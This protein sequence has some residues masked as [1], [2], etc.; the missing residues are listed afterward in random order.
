MSHN[1][2]FDRCLRETL[3]YEGEAFVNHPKDPGGPTKYG[4]TLRTLADWRGVGPEELSEEAVR[5]LTKDEARL[6]YLARYWAPIRGDE[7]PPGVDLVVFDYAVNSGT[8]TAARALQRVLGVAVD[9]VIGRQ[10]LAALRRVP[11]E[12]VIE[13]VCEQRLE[14]M[15]SLSN[16]GVFGVGWQRRVRGIR[17]T[18]LA[19]SRAGLP[20]SEVAKT[21]TAKAATVATGAVTTAAVALREMEPVVTAVWPWFER[22][23]IYGALAVV[24]F[25]ILAG[26]W[27]WRSKRA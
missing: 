27:H 2:K 9:G 14:F 12:T 15:R 18:A 13:K 20:V 17:E 7:L 21:D 19:W 16:W 5:S 22:Y 4:I 11:P 1:A 23:G 8:R 24:A 3:R 26:I 10:T 25:V 6:I